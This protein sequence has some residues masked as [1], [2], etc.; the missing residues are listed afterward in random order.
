M[1]DITANVI[2]SMPSQLFTMARSFKAV[3]N[4]KIYIGKIDTDPVN[5]ENQI[6]VYVENED[7]SHVPVSQPIII[8]AAGYPVYNGQIAKFVTVQGHSMAVYDAYGAKQFY[9]PNVLKY[10]PSSKFSYL[11]INLLNLWDKYSKL[12]GYNLIGYFKPGVTI[13]NPCDVVFHLDSATVYRYTATIPHTITSDEEPSGFWLPVKEGIEAASSDDM[14]R[15]ISEGHYIIDKNADFIIPGQIT[16]SYNR[17]DRS[18][19][20]GYQYRYGGIKHQKQPFGVFEDAC[21]FTAVAA[22]REAEHFTGILGAGTGQSLAQYGSVDTSAT[23]FENTALPPVYT[24]TGAT[25]NSTGASGIN[26]DTK[27]IKLNMV[28]V[29]IGTSQTWFGLIRSF[30]SSS[31]TVD[32]WYEKTSGTLSIPSGTLY[33]SP[34][35]RVWGNNTVVTIPENSSASSAVGMEVMLNLYKDGSGIDSQVYKAINNN[36]FNPD[37]IVDS[38]YQAVGKFGKAHDVWPGSTYSYRSWGA[39][40]YGFFSDHDQ[41]GI[42]IL[43]PNDAA[44]VLASQV[45]G[46]GAETNVLI[47]DPA[48]SIIQ[49]NQKAVNE[50]AA[51]FG[52]NGASGV[53]IRQQ[54][55]GGASN[56]DAV[57]YVGASTETGRSINC[58]GTINTSG[59]DYAEYVEKSEACGCISPGDICGINSAGKIT[60]KFDDSI[61]FVIKSTEPSMVGG[62]TW[63]SLERPKYPSEEWVAWDKAIRK[64][65]PNKPD[66]KIIN[67]LIKGG[68]DED[69]AKK[70]YSKMME[71]YQKEH[72]LWSI[73]ID[74]LMK[75]EPSKESKEYKEWLRKTEEIRRNFDR[76]AFCGRVPVNVKGGKPGDYLIPI[77]GGDGKISGCFVSNPDFNQFKLS[78]GRVWNVDNHGLVTV[79][80]LMI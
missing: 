2:V 41:S 68:V 80:V 13:N 19:S 34:V 52:A 62:D 42:K 35:Y 12:P 36:A 25:F 10:D 53:T 43:T 72:E 45:G 39:T 22:T 31:I 70:Q 78:V 61:R 76:V 23:Y 3:A 47:I 18:F 6:Q 40:S 20:D 54:S 71:S 16:N 57:M 50:V 49:T 1:T 37:E 58:A 4:G 66:K 55:G 15:L 69:E 44:F 21:V 17:A 77:K 48:G 74:S 73:T 63:S 67:N 56:T 5:P 60:D 28:A 8:N 24:I 65:E 32:G 33:I 9:F 27:K 30:N 75:S 29:V 46:V 14:T 79:S 7:G 51:Q 11:D 26:I 64:K 59:A 38:A